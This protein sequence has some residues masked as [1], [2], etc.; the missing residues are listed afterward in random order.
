M[1]NLDGCGRPA[2]VDVAMTVDP[3]LGG[4]VPVGDEADLSDGSDTEEED[5]ANLDAACDPSCDQQFMQNLAGLSAAQATSSRLSI[6]Q[7]VTFQI[8]QQKDDGARGGGASA[9]ANIEGQ[10]RT[11][12][13]GKKRRK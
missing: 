13:G 6:A 4:A 7:V 11:K 5:V 2:L 1:R 9:P 10:N 3:K 12:G 8:P